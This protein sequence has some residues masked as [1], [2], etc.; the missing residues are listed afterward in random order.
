M[1]ASSGDDCLICKEII[2]SFNQ[3]LEDPSTEKN[4]EDLMLSGCNSLPAGY[5]NM[6]SLNSV[7]RF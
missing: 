5:Q 2:N 7:A 4:I 6:V 3:A 1:A